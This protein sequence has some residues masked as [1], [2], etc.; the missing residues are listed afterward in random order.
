MT[1]PL[2]AERL[3]LLYDFL[4]E[5]PPFDK[6]NMPPSDEIKFVVTRSNSTRGYYVRPTGKHEIGISTVCCGWMNAVVWVMAHEMVHLH[7]GDVD[8]PGARKSCGGME[9]PN[10]EHNAAFKKLAQIVCKI[11]GYDPHEFY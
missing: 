5:C 1:L 2:N 4:A 8:K 11:H 9:T 3:A 7:Q 6:W 10:A